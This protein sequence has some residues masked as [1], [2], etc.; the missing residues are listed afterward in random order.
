MRSR[1]LTA[2]A[3]LLAVALPAAA[4]APKEKGPA[5]TFQTLPPGKLLDDIK[6][7]AKIVAGDDAVKEID[8]HLTDA[9]GEKG[10]TGVDMLRPVVGYAELN[11]K[12][13]AS[14]A[15]VVVPVTGEKDFLDLLDRLKCTVE[16]AKDARGLYRVLPP[17]TP[18]ADPPALLRF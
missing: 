6:A 4:Q 17:H 13:E 16:E 5:L 12:A 10:F 11:D 18:Q 14:G 7:A 15:V 9:L 2:A 8:K 3:A 1:F